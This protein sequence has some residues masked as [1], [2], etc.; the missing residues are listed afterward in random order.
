MTIMSLD[1]FPPHSIASKNSNIEKVMKTSSVTFDEDAIFENAI[2]ED[3]IFKDAIFLDSIFEDEKD[4]DESDDEEKDEDDDRNR[5]ENDD[6]MMNETL[7]NEKACEKDAKNDGVGI[8]VVLDF[9]S[10]R[11]HAYRVTI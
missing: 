5:D 3:A 6:E 2:F 9:I 7:L 4:E 10:Q 11:P 8:I 1:F